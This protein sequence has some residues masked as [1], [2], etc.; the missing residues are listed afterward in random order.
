MN[1]QSFDPQVEVD[2]NKIRELTSNP[3]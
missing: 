3:K 2:I 1:S